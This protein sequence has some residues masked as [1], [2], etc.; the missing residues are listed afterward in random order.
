MIEMCRTRRFWLLNI[1]SKTVVYH[2]NIRHWLIPI[3]CRYACCY[4]KHR[5][6][7]YGIINS[8]W[9][10]TRNTEIRPVSSLNNNYTLRSASVIS[11]LN[12][13][14]KRRHT[15]SSIQATYKMR[16]IWGPIG[17]KINFVHIFNESISRTPKFL[18]CFLWRCGPTWARVSSTLR[19]LDHTQRRTT[20]GRTP[21]DEWSAPRR[22]L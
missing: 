4:K 21:L 3:H 22:D 10:S 2:F 11:R 15:K 17:T 7:F 18:F 1:L 20:V 16:I 13:C 19:F 14:K 12:L 5:G 8:S 9:L 6:H